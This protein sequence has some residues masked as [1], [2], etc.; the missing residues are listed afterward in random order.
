MS[1]DFSRFPKTESESSRC[2]WVLRHAKWTMICLARLAQGGT[3]GSASFQ[4][5][6]G[7]EEKIAYRHGTAHTYLQVCL[8][9]FLRHIGTYIVQYTPT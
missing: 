6:L 5:L 7:G 8:F 3:N 1:D 4:A 9:T 2:R